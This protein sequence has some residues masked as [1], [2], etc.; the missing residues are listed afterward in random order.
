[1]LGL[2]ALVVFI[3]G[4]AI[5]VFVTQL[6]WNY[7]M[8]EVFGVKQIEF[9]HTLALLILATIFFGGHCNASSVSSMNSMMT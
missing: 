3:V 2:S 4:V 8:P 7:V 6:L 1:M 9:W 5:I